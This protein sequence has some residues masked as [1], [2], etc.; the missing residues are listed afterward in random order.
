M[1]C[2]CRHNSN[3]SRRREIYHSEQHV[4]NCL[5]LKFKI[6]LEASGVVVASKNSISFVEEFYSPNAAGETDALRLAQLLFI[7]PVSMGNLRGFLTLK[8]VAPFKQSL[9]RVETQV[10]SIT[11][12][13]P[14]CY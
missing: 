11:K 7:L 12:T 6:P 14:P 1:R 3:Q 13:S 5:G 4:P 9:L 2:R 8:N 10:L